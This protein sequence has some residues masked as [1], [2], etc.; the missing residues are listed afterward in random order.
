MRPLLKAGICGHFGGG[1][2]FSDGQTVKTVILTEKLK[3]I[4]GAEQVLTL[5]TYQWKKHVFQLVFRCLYMLKSCENI[6]VLPS[7][8]GVK[9][10]IPLFLF[11]NKLYHRKLHYVIIGGWLP[12]VLK[13]SP[14]L[15]DKM[16]K[17]DGLYGETVSLTEEL[18]ALG[19]SNVYLLPNFKRLDIAD[20]VS[21]KANAP[22][23]LYTFSRVTK[24]KGISEAAEAV[25]TAN[26]RLERIAYTLDIWGGIDPVYAEEFEKLRS[27]FPAYIAYKGCLS[28]KDTTDTLKKYFALLFPTRYPREGI[29]GSLL[30]SYAA[31]VPVLSSHFVNA[32]QIIE[33]GKTGL[34]L[35]FEHITEELTEVLVRLADY[36]EKLIGMREACTLKAADYQADKVVDEFADLICG[37]DILT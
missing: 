28:Y 35:N 17:L 34:I 6:L 33:D 31:G 14:R 11:F 5:D 30:D 16:K 37:K 26:E 8:N 25:R 36:P 7:W 18:K 4:W 3:E 12:D 10:L 19:L 1:R 22:L 13:A 32:P 27:E 2:S 21:F 15:L 9:V 23:A 20:D 24:K 29:P